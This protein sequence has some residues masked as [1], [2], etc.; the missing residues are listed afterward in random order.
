MIISKT[1]YLKLN[2]RNIKTIINNGYKENIEYNSIVDLDIKYLPLNSHVIINVKCDNCGKIKKLKYQT[3]N[4]CTNNNKEKYYCN[5]RDC[6]NLKR[7]ISI[8]KKYNVDNV[9]QLDDIKQKIKSTNLLLYGHENPQQNKEIKEKTEKTNIIKYGSR[10]P[11]Q[12]EYIKNKIKK[13]NNLKYGVDYPQQSALIR[14]KYSSLHKSSKLELELLEFIKNNYN[15][16]ILNN[17]RNIINGYEIDIYLPELNIAFE[18]NGLYWHNEVNK[19]KNY[20]MDKTNLCQKIGIELIHIWEDQWEFQ[21]DIIKSMV[22]Y[23]LNKI[24]N[25]INSNDTILKEIKDNLIISNFLKM[26]N[27]NGYLKCKINIGLYYNNEIISIMSFKKDKKNIYKLLFFCNKLNTNIINAE[28]KIFNFFIDKYKP[29]K[30]V[31]IADRSFINY[32]LYNN[33]N[34]K[35]ESITN[36][37]YH[38]IINRKRVNSKKSQKGK[39]YKIYDCGN[40]IFSYIN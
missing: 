2:N 12:N 9:F 37:K 38:Y 11:F 39:I 18:F 30:M 23:K 27:I 29:L 15:G 28:H 7:K 19:H 40:L 33:L 34:F 36:P 32:N 21:K 10:N 24:S 3:Y 14:S 25:I 8:N 4:K 5:S 31:S 20:H 13:T 17:K 35:L 16:Q 26:N 6:I 1:V 22:L